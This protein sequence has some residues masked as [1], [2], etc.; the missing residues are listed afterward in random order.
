[1]PNVIKFYHAPS[2]YEFLILLFFSESN[3]FSKYLLPA[4]CQALF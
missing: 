4:E 3:L 2:P 1:M